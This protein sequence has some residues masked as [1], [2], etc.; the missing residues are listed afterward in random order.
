MK[1]KK[2][3]AFVLAAV[4]IAA[5]CLSGFAYNESTVNGEEAVAEFSV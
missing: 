4:I 5:S 1:M 2:A 3:A